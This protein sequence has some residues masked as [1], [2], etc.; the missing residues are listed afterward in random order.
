MTMAAGAALAHHGPANSDTNARVII[1]FS[2]TDHQKSWQQ[3]LRLAGRHL[4]PILFVLL[5]AEGAAAARIGSDA[6]AAGVI[7]VPVDAADAVAMYR[8]AFESIA[9]ARRRTGSTLILSTPYRIKGLKPPRN[10][11]PVTKMELY[12]KHKGI[13][14]KAG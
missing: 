10:E 13:S 4:S 12:L 6:V 7:T 5:D 1:A 11:D 3:A 9:R 2:T 14:I 8:V